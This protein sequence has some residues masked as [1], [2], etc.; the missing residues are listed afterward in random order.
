MARTK[1]TTGPLKGRTFDIPDT[2]T[3]LDHHAITDG[4][5]TVTDG[6]ASWHQG[7]DA[8]AVQ[9]P[10]NGVPETSTPTTE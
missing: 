1:I 2:A 7:K 3:T 5:Y 8:P 10:D 4:H 9:A 6:K